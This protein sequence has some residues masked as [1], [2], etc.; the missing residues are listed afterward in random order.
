MYYRNRIDQ[1]DFNGAKFNSFLYFDTISNRKNLKKSGQLI[2]ELK[3]HLNPDN[4]VATVGPFADNNNMSFK[5]GAWPENVLKA[6]KK[7]YQLTGQ[8][9][10]D[11]KFVLTNN[12]YSYFDLFF[13]QDK[14]G[15][16]TDKTKLEVPPMITKATMVDGVLTEP[17][18]HNYQ[19][20]HNIF[21][22]NETNNGVIT[23]HPDVVC[24]FILR[25]VDTAGEAHKSIKLSY[26]THFKTQRGVFRPIAPFSPT[27]FRSDSEHYSQSDILAEIN[28]FK[29]IM[30]VQNTHVH[31]IGHA[32]GLDH[33]GKVLNE[34]KCVTAMASGDQNANVCY[35]T[36]F[37]S[38]S[39]ILGRGNRLLPMNA[40]PWKHALKLMTK[41][42]AW[43][44]KVL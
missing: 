18:V 6:F 30:L 43:Q 34:P 38:A 10:W 41:A 5:T 1:V 35:G 23:V 2:I 13:T 39:N 4:T 36:T 26:F 22:D 19:I 14:K 31:E 16:L 24:R 33:S 15:K 7:T 21:F 12:S 44:A 3:V 17:D 9:F 25:L 8:G 27:Y 28:F 11:R 40:E 32:I 42:N 20:Q 29:G 37:K